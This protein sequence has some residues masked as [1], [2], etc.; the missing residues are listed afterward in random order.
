MISIFII[1]YLTIQL[2]YIKIIVLSEISLI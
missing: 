1:Y 2:T